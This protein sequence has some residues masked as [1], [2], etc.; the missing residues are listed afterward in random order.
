M[1]RARQPIETGDRLSAKRARACRY[2]W[3]R[4]PGP[5]SGN[6][7]ALCRRIFHRILTAEVSLRESLIDDGNAQRRVAREK[8]SPVNESNF[9]RID[10]AGR[11]TE[12]VASHHRGSVRVANR[13]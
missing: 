3:R 8:I 11:D 9:H 1:P 2:T 4:E 6:D 5:R 10:P 12:K 13:Q 7:C